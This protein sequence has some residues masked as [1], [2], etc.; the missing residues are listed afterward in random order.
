MDFR[1]FAKFLITMAVGLLILGGSLFAHWKQFPQGMSAEASHLR[2]VVV[3]TA[4][5]TVENYVSRGEA[6]V[7]L[8]RMY[9]A[10]ETRG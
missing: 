4:N 9:A 8:D 6:R 5:L 10:D 1:K 2:G 7:R 3:G